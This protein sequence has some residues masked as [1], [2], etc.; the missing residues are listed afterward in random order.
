MIP[1]ILGNAVDATENAN[2]DWIAYIA[3]RATEPSEEILKS[4]ITGFFVEVFPELEPNRDKLEQKPYRVDF[5]CIG[6]DGSGVRLHPH[7]HGK[8][9]ISFG[10]LDTWGGRQIG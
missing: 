7:K 4:P 8:E 9:E 10:L 3:S 2:F 5:V 6:E 1:N